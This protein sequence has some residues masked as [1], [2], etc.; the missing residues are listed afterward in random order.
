MAYVH[1]RKRNELN[2]M[3]TAE[4]KKRSEM[5]EGLHCN[6]DVEDNHSH[7]TDCLVGAIHGVAYAL[8]LLG[9]A[10]ATTSM[11]AIEALGAIVQEGLL[12]ITREI[13]YRKHR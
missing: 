8:K 10:D 5:R 13:G 12:G 7:E 9:N 11:G 6:C 3:Y 2:K 4:G 1:S